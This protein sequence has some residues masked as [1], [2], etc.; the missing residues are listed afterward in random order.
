MAEKRDYYDVLGV[1]RGASQ[2][3]I[4]RAYRKLA[5]KHHPDVNPSDTEAETRFKELNEANEVLS[6]PEKRAMYDQY[7]HE[8]ANGGGPGGYGG[9]TVDFGGFGDI[10]DMFFG[11]GGG[12]QSTRQ[13]PVAERGSDL[14]Y[15]LELTLEEAA[16]GVDKTIRITRPEPCGKCDGTGV[17]PGGKIETCSMCRGSGQVRQ[18]Q[19]TFLGTQVVVTTCPTCRGEGRTISS[20]CTECGGQGRV[21]KTSEKT[22][23][24]PAG[25]DDGNR[26]RVTGEGEAG[27]RGGPAGDLY[28][29]TFIK[30]HEVFQRKGNDIWCE[31]PVTFAQASLGATINVRTLLDEQK[32]H[33]SEGTQNEEVYTLREKGMPDPRGRRKG[34]LNVVIKVQT[35]TKLSDEQ[36]DLLKQ[37]AELR[38]E[39]LEV[40]EEKGFFERVRDA[41][42]GR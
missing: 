18:Q 28:V 10:F 38:G 15:D 17:G 41:L 42:G 8:A 21:R 22:V 14:R 4:K 24:I 2:D 19:Q 27:V 33:I 32:L 5:R 39:N 3:E 16:V 29:V 9:F 25:V 35:P 26:V 23:H 1:E 7:G 20:P 11:A 34:D 40:H 12:R 37:F 6:D 13:R 31:V 36:K 30:P